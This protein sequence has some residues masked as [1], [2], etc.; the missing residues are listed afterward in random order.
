MGDAERKL[1]VK[2]LLLSPHKIGVKFFIESPPI[3]LG[4]LATALRKLGHEVDLKDCIIE[5][6]DNPMTLEYIQKVK[7][8]VVGINVFS[9]ALRSV[10]ELLAL[11]RTLPESPL[12]ILG[13]PHCSGVPEDVL[14]F[15]DKADYAFT[16][17]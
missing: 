9:S 13:G 1:E 12:V 4:F 3:G 17:E 14:L 5:G 7:P 16:L 2:F 8:D 6:W 11:I 10:N 15:F